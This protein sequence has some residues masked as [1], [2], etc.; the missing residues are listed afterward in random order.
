[1]EGGQEQTSNEVEDNTT[2]D[3]LQTQ[4]TK[5]K[6]ASGSG[7]ELHKCKY[8]FAIKHAFSIKYVGIS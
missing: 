1:M 8:I 6:I 4:S 3:T 2:Q 7:K 5:R